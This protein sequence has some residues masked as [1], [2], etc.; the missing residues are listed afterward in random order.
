MDSFKAITSLTGSFLKTYFA[1]IASF[2]PMSV[3]LAMPMPPPVLP[4]LGAAA[5]V[6]RATKQRTAR[7]WTRHGGGR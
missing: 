4:V 1:E 2:M 7:R 6:F 3:M 5:A